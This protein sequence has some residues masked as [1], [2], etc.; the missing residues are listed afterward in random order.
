MPP[1]VRQATCARRGAE[2]FVRFVECDPVV[3]ERALR[4][5]GRTRTLLVAPPASDRQ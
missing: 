1:S 2:T 4:Y 3:R 5:G